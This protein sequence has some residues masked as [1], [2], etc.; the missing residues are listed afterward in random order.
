MSSSEFYLDC[1]CGKQVAVT[2]DLAGAEVQCRCGRSLVV[3]S[4]SR[5]RSDAGL[6]AYSPGIA[7]RVTRLVESE[8]QF[9]GDNCSQC[10]RQTSDVLSGTIV[11]EEVYRRG[12]GSTFSY[13]LLLMLVHPIALLIH[14]MFHRDQ[15]VEELGREVS[16]PLRLPC[17]EN[18]RPATA[19]CLLADLSAAIRWGLIATGAILIFAHLRFESGRV[20]LALVIAGCVLWLTHAVIVNL[21]QRRLKRWARSNPL[22]QELLAEYPDARIVLG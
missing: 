13:R 16:A 19:P 4:L 3:P 9:L 11:C 2:A 12:Q 15:E 6:L 7:D 21:R 17:C 10:G 8:E 20:G 14:L 22:Y 18:C 1:S 5:L